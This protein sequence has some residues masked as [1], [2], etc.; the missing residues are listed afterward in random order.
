MV[1]K[2]IRGIQKKIVFG[3][4]KQVAEKSLLE[5]VRDNRATRPFRSLVHEILRRDER[6]FLCN[7]RPQSALA[8]RVWNLLLQQGANHTAARHMDLHNKMLAE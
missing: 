8:G 3:L 7:A 6:E 1:Y 2:S 5:Q 4:V